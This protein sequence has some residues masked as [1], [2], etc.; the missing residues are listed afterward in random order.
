MSSFSSRRRLHQRCNSWVSSEVLETRTLL[1]VDIIFDYRFA[2]NASLFT[3]ETFDTFAEIEALF[4]SRLDDT[5]MPW[6]TSSLQLRNPST[7][8]VDM[9]NQSIGMN[10]FVIFV[11]SRNI[12]GP[13]GTLALGSPVFSFTFDRDETGDH[14]G[15]GGSIALDDSE[16]WN[17]SI[18]SLPGDDQVDLYSNVLH[19]VGHILGFGTSSTQGTTAWM[20]LVN[21]TNATFSGQASNRVWGGPV[22]LEADLAH[23][24]NNNFEPVGRETVFDP[25]IGRGDR[26]TMTSLDWAVLDDVGWDVNAAASI[27]ISINETSISESGSTRATATVER[28]G[29]RVESPET[30]YLSGVENGGE[31]SFPASVTIP[32]NA[33]TATFDIDAVD[34][35]VDDG[36]LTV[37]IRANSLR[38]ENESAEIEL[39]VLDDDDAALPDL[40]VSEFVPPADLMAG[41]SGAIRWNVTNEGDTPAGAFSIRHYLGLGSTFDPNNDV[42]LAEESVDELAAGAATGSMSTSITLPGSADAFYPG[43]GRYFVR[44]VVDAA[45]QVEESDE[46]NASSAALQISET[47]AVPSLDFDGDRAFLPLT[48]GIVG[49]RYL[50]GFRGESL[51]RDAV[52][53]SAV[54]NSAASMETWLTEVAPLA[55]DVDADNVTQPL[56]DGLLLLRFLAGFRGESLVADAV[57]PAGTR[58][59][60]AE[61]VAFLESFTN[62]GSS[63][64]GAGSAAAGQSFAMTLQLPDH[65]KET[66]DLFAD[67]RLSFGHGLQ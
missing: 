36:D 59:D 45:S 42:L 26:K 43:D 23:L 56:S 5:L 58:T 22:P 25:G 24:S 4:E 16:D 49:I 33:R 8:A 62:A 28:V 67:G 17:L 34:D 37:K 31:V 1:S 61:I 11:G 20:N 51:S 14:S 53:E 9:V 35:T 46:D 48:D 30:V 54:R 40:V 32:A 52:A 60:P 38:A 3:Q 64:G 57:N 44:T 2:D 50:A 65:D 29:G 10:E 18:D 15:W 12:N 41:E 27:E 63:G 21:P 66:D 39:L 13:G 7:G 19:E 6:W 47:G 55:L